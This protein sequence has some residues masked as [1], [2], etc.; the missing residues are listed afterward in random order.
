MTRMEE[1]TALHAELAQEPKGLEMSVERALKRRTAC[2]KKART[3][4]ASGASIAACFAVSAMKLSTS[5]K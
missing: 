5:I 4:I 2:R 1:Y 3:W